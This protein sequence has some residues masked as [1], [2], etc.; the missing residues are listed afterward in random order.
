MLSKTYTVAGGIVFLGETCT[1]A[2][3]SNTMGGICAEGGPGSQRRRIVS[4]ASTRASRNTIGSWL[5]DSSSKSKSS[6]SSPKLPP[7]MLKA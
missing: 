6:L 3:S 7:E 1:K 4:G 2:S 5:T